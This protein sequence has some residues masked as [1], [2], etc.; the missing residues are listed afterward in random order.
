MFLLRNITLRASEDEMAGWHHDAMDLGQ[1]LGDGERQG[2]LACCRP[3]GHKELD[4]TGQLHNSNVP[5][6]PTYWRVF[7]INGC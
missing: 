4:T 5:S 7:I 6:M 3:S 2:G 1:V